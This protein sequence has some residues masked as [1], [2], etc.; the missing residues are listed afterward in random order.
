VAG[1][2]RD[3]TGDAAMP[4]LFASGLMLVTIAA[5]AVFWRIE[6]RPAAGVD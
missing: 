1:Y 5:V 2:L 3:V 6:G 4:L